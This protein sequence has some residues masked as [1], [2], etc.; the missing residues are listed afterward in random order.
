M[1]AEYFT[2][3]DV[4]YIKKRGTRT[5]VSEGVLRVMKVMMELQMIMVAMVMMV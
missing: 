2:R 4:A 1:D 5:E 3:A